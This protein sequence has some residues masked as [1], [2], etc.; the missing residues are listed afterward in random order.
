MSKD[1]IYRSQFRLPYSLYEELKEEADRNHR[2][3][4]AEVVDRLAKSLGYV[5]LAKDDE[6][7][8]DMDDDALEAI[9]KLDEA[10]NTYLKARDHRNRL[11]HG[12]IKKK[13]K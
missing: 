7:A 4:N 3:L 13:E 9:K 5:N 8:P 10:V 12:V 11:M 1:D 2:S 6:D